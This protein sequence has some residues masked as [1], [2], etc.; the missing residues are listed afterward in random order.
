MDETFEEEVSK[1]EKLIFNNM[2][3]GALQ[4]KSFS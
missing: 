4:I 2:N 3:D 1:E